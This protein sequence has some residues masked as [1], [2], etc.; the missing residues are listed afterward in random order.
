MKRE[1]GIMEQPR[2]G[3][4]IPGHV[5]SSL[6]LVI[7]WLWATQ[8][9]S[10]YEGHLPLNGAFERQTPS[11]TPLNW[12]LNTIPTGDDSRT[13]AKLSTVS[14]KGEMSL[15]I[16]S[17]GNGTSMAIHES[18]IGFPVLRMLHLGTAE[19]HYKVLSSEL[20]GKNLEF[21]LELLDGE[22]NL[23]HQVI[24]SPP[25]EHV[26]DGQWHRDTFN[27]DI[28]QSRRAKFIRISFSVNGEGEIGPGSWLIDEVQVYDRPASILME[29][30][31]LQKGVFS[32]S[33]T[34]RVQ[35]VVE[36]QGG[37]FYYDLHSKM[38]VPED[39][40]VLGSPEK[41]INVVE[42]GVD[43]T[44]NWSLSASQEGI[45]Q[46]EIN[47]WS[48]L[49]ESLHDPMI[50]VI[51]SA[52]FSHPV[53]RP[54]EA[55]CTISES[56]IALEN[57]HLRIVFPRTEGGM[58]LFAIQSW[59]GSWF[60]MGVA[61][62][63][64]H[65]LNLPSAG[66]REL[67]L[68]T[69]SQFKSGNETDGTWLTLSGSTKDS[70][71]VNWDFDYY[72]HLNSSGT[73]VEMELRV[74]PSSNR[75][76]L[77]L[78]GPRLLA[79]ETSFGGR[80][81]QGLFPGIEY[82]LPNERSS[83]TDFVDPPDN[84]RIVPHPLKITAPLMVI[85]N[86]GN[87]VGMFWDPLQAWD[88]ENSL[89]CAK[90]I[91]PNW[92]N[93]QDNHLMSIFAPSIPRWVNEN[94]DQAENPYDFDDPIIL[95]MS[96]FAR[97]NTSVI[98]TYQWWLEQHGTP[99]PPQKPRS[100]QE[101]FDL[102]TTCYNDICWV[103]EDKAW[104]HTHLDDP[105]W[106][107]WDP[108]VA[109]ALWH[110]SAYTDNATLRSQIRDQV[111]EALEAR[112]WRNSDEDL[113]LHIGGLERALNSKYG[114]VASLADSQ[115]PDGSWPYTGKGSLGETGDTSSGWV[116]SKAR[117]LLKFGR[118]TGDQ[119]AIR[120]GF[121]ALD[122]LDSELRPEGAQTWELQLHVP[123]ILASS[124][125]LECYL[126]AYEISGKPKYLE[127]ARYWALTGLP[128]VYMWNPTER[129]IM[130]YG[131][132]PVFGATAYTHPWFGIIVQWNGLDYAY[133]LY[134]LSQYDDSLPWHRI[135]E[136]ITVCGMQMQRYPGGP[137]DEMLGMYPDAFSAVLGTDPYYFDINPR[138]ISLC[139][140]ALS[141]RD[142]T[143]RTRIIEVD[144]RT[145]H[146]NTVGNLTQVGQEENGFHF[147][148]QYP[149]GDVSYSLVSCIS[150]PSKVTLNHQT[151]PP[152]TELSKVEQG[153]R[154]LPE[155]V[156][157]LKI[158][159]TREDLIDIQG[160]RAITHLR[161]SSNSTWEFPAS[162][163]G[164]GEPN[165]LEPLSVSEGKIQARSTGND[166][167]ILGPSIRLRASHDCTARINMSISRGER[168]QL[169]WTRSD[170]KMY[171]ES[172]SISFDIVADGNFHEYILDLGEN[173][174]WSGV[175]RGLRLDPT[176]STGAEISIDSI[177]IP[178][179]CLIP[180]IL[181]LLSLLIRGCYRG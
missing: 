32:P 147:K 114:W 79:G 80:R 141:G 39:L 103:S 156:L 116:A 149:Q 84:M 35:L 49:N 157:L 23:V 52:D 97:S 12:S 30:A 18:E 20:A 21:R 161:F 167:F 36:N 118:I 142:E 58:P 92:V 144:G 24:H 179:P 82:L 48:P 59:N 153:W 180:A 27:V 148:V 81:N 88:G 122:Y 37:A 55:R 168:A 63:I 10:A 34:I 71:G 65:A 102:C 164:W 178:E 169:F 130:R 40:T 107:F 25:A 115:N 101:T 68:L 54:P 166:P 165:M 50:L 2:R 117:S 155:G 72:F 132:I 53:T 60:T 128:F 46:V 89:P 8:C 77:R 136:G 61:T 133:N 181:T 174:E 154:Y 76:L 14:Y 106:I 87:A 45:Y 38:E 162:N 91:S 93:K 16:T 152:A 163:Q 4:K 67:I 86:E 126:E 120:T 99:E 113:A 127:K 160:S 105:K 176:D 64:G 69:P 33:Q 134:R 78:S 119:E 3:I 70:E 73:Q 26:G 44:I 9:I 123:D 98:D 171:S 124:Y 15:K 95:E 150:K 137:H 56:E 90:Y 7:I 104:K 62:P 177:R 108:M 143:T 13:L 138:F 159:H 28:L 129:P 47:S 158:N 151:L 172:K 74:V 66:L 19:Y 140:F 125:I 85:E 42:P 96:I 145:V 43:Y 5:I 170:S 29:K 83:G 75:T 112:K 111:N 135:A 51:S 121:K 41:S 100:W 146:F 139:A 94:E 110:H 131:S 6:M 57:E 173:Q 11:G 17:T 175:I 109:N 1:S 31:T 22:G